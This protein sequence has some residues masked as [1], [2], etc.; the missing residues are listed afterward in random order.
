MITRVC[1]YCKANR[2]SITYMLLAIILFI[3]LFYRIIFALD[4]KYTNQYRGTQYT[5]DEFKYL[6]MI[7]K[8]LTSGN[9]GHSAEHDAYVTPGYPM[10]LAAVMGI[11]GTGSNG[12]LAVKLIQALLSVASSG[13]VFLLCAKLLESRGA[14][15]VAA[16]LISFYPPLILI[17]RYLLTETLYIFLIILYFYVQNHALERNKKMLYIAAGALFALSV[18]VRPMIVVLLPLPYIYVYVSRKD[19]AE[20]LL[21]IRGF[22]LFVLAF[23][24][25]MLPW[26]IRNI[27]TLNQ[28]IPLATQGNPFYAGIVR[29]FT[30]LAH[31]ENEYVDGLKLFFDELTSKP[32]QTIYWFTFGK[33]EIL[34]KAPFYYLPPEHSYPT[35]LIIPMHIYIVVFGSLGLLAGIFIKKLRMI[36]L[37]LLL[38]IMLSLLFIPT[39]RFGLQY[40]PFFAVFSNVVYFYIKSNRKKKLRKKSILR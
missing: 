13:L 30:A 34:F 40:M 6:E 39:R 24:L 19:R 12:V 10:F 29:D 16:A 36:S 26:W 5:Y 35:Y 17:S 7:D 21:I 1:E 37:Y 18:L 3:G 22:S 23:V 32:L 14:G 9:Y 15:L 28:F 25:V 33:L 11:F 27:I 8:L 2:A 31:P 4:I 20:R 38:Y